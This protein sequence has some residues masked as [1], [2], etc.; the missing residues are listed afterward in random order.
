MTNSGSSP[1]PPKT[2]FKVTLLQGVIGAVSLAGTTAI[3]LVVQR[4]VAPAPPASSPTPVPAQ[5]TPSPQ[6]QPTLNEL[7]VTQ[8]S[9]DGDA[10][11]KG[12]GK[13]KGK[14]DD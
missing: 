12:K 4:L 9:N 6:V 2:G 8:L 5:V 7:G 3:P 11:D 1:E 10:H 13:K 14:K